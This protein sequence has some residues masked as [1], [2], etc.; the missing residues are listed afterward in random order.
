MSS[1]LAAPLIVPNDPLT[2]V[3]SCR[4]VLFST[5]SSAAPLQAKTLIDGR[6][7]GSGRH[8]NSGAKRKT[9]R[10]NYLAAGLALSLLASCAKKAPPPPAAVA[11]D[12]ATATVQSVPIIGDW[13]ATTDGYV[14]AQ[15]QPQVSGYLVRQSI[16]YFTPGRG[17]GTIF[18]QPWRDG[19]LTGPAVPAVKLPFSFRVDYSG[20][21]YDFSKD[22]SSVVYARP[23]GQADLYL[24]K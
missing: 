15:I 16:L 7:L 4:A 6:N 5:T 3:G 2:A 10:L 23:T 20:N 11:V 18:R 1:S 24:L 21:A 8:E 9:S 19:K 14:N 17:E 12:T 13:V 22:L